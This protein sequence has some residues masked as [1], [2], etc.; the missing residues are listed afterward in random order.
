MKKRA[1]LAA[2]A[3]IAANPSPARAD[4]AAPLCTEASR[5]CYAKTARAYFDAILAGQADK[6]PFADTVRVT[7]QNHLIATDRAAFLQQFRSTGAT[8]RLRNMRML[9]DAVSGQVAVL[10][11][12]DV[13]MPGQA[14]FTVR[15]IQRLKIDRGL[16]TE[17]EL[18][19]FSDPKPE[20][21]WPDDQPR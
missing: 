13:E 7:E 4:D 8:K 5:E 16:I 19:I 21:L 20:P 18:I 15:R 10:V 12:A 2:L 1:S 9:V 6:V 14:P 3:V 17:V 11:L